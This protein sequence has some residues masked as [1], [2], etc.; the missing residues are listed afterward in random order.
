MVQSL[1]STPIGGKSPSTPT[2]EQRATSFREAGS[3][4]ASP[5]KAAAVLGTA[6]VAPAMTPTAAAAAPVVTAA[7]P[8]EAAA[9]LQAQAQPPSSSPE[10]AAAAPAA[11]VAKV[12]QAAEAEAGAENVDANMQATP[13]GRKVVVRFAEGLASSSKPSLRA[14]TP[15]TTLLTSNAGASPAVGSS[16]PGWRTGPGSAARRPGPSPLQQS[17]AKAAPAPLRAVALDSDSDSSSCDFSDDEVGARGV[18]MHLERM[19]L[20]P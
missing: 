18:G 13:A 7:A 8:P 4:S 16:S 20:L 11:A 5:S 17:A 14:S 12:Q 9:T 1:A 2:T 3:E 6:A 19:A 15:G 10:G